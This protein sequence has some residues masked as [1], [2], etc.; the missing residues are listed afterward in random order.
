MYLFLCLP[1]NLA[2]CLYEIIQRVKKAL[3]RRFTM[4]EG[5]RAELQNKNSDR[6]LNRC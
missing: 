1:T 6:K 4:T 5:E 3:E 2:M